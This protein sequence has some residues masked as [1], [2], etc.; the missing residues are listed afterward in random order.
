M[1]E[2]KKKKI[3]VIL[4]VA[5]IAVVAL[6]IL[7]VPRIIDKMNECKVEGCTYDSIS[8]GEYCSDHTCVEGDCIERHVK[9]DIYCKEHLNNHTCEGGYECTN[10]AIKG[11]DFCED[12]TC[13]VDGCYNES[14]DDE[15]YCSAHQCVVCGAFVKDASHKC[16]EHKGYEKCLSCD[17]YKTGV[18]LITIAGGD[19]RDYTGEK[20]E[21]CTDCWEEYKEL[22]IYDVP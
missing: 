3:I 8:N 22:S 6:C 5:A 19:T 13:A 7:F 21:W 10:K 20:Y 11:Y 4:I 17:K 14:D 16:S 18:E 9:G 1:T 15:K 2:K 12:H